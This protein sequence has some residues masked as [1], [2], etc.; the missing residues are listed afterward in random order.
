MWEYHVDFLI[1]EMN[2]H[3]LSIDIDVDEIMWD[4]IGDLEVIVE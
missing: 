2:T 3:K 4:K 1:H